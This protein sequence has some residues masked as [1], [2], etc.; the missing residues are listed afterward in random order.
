M[1]MYKFVRNCNLSKFFYLS[2]QF[3]KVGSSRHH[4]EIARSRT[5]ELVC[6]APVARMCKRRI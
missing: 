1:K 5:I 2:L 6:V 4:D 3:E